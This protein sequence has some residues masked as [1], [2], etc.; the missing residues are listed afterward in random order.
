MTDDEMLA[1]LY[2]ALDLLRELKCDYGQ[3]SLTV[4]NGE[5]KHVNI[6]HEVP[7]DTGRQTMVK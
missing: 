1:R 6:S 3:I 2:Q 5:V 7:L 4:K